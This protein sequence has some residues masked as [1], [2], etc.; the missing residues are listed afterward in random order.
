MDI[1]LWILPTT[2]AALAGAAALFKA[3][4]NIN[5]DINKLITDTREKKSK[6]TNVQLQRSCIHICTNP[7]GNLVSAYEPRYSEQ[8]GDVEGY[9]ISRDRKWVGMFHLWEC[10]ICADRKQDQEGKPDPLKEWEDNLKELK[11]RVQTQERLTRELD[12]I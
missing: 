9:G 1:N 5:C 6:R 2:I 12:K 8:V 7:S 11:K 3:S 10:R 4:I